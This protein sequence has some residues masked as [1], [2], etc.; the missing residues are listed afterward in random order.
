MFFMDISVKRVG[1]FFL[2]ILALSLCSIEKD[3][4]K[5]GPSLYCLQCFLFTLCEID[6]LSTKRESRQHSDGI[7]RPLDTV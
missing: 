6:G 2:T 3:V 5:V 4:T 1:T 7:L